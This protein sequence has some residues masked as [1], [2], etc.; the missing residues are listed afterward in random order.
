MYFFGDVCGCSLVPAKQSFF[1]SKGK[2]QY[3]KYAA[4]TQ[5][6]FLTSAALLFKEIKKKKIGV[7]LPH[8][9]MVSSLLKGSFLVSSSLCNW[10][11]SR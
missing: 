2:Q 1:S 4:C 5:Q 11:V 7:I 8:P 3:L 6:L 10:S 9:I